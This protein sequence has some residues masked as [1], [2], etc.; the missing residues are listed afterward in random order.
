[1]KHL[2]RRGLALCLSL[3]LLLPSALAVGSF[4]KTNPYSPFPDL[5]GHWAE[6]CVRVCVETGL[7]EG[8][9]GRFAP[10]AVLTN[11]E[12]AAIAARIREVFTGEPIPAAG[13]PWYQVYLDYLARAGI[14]VT[15]PRAYATRQSFFS[16]LS[17]VLP[18]SALTAINSIRALPDTN[19]PAVLKFYN[20]GILTGTDQYGTFDG[21]S[22]L[23]RAQ[24]AAMAARIAEPALRQRFTPAGQVPAADYAD[25]ALVMTVEGVPVTYASFR[26]V[27][28]SLTGEVMELYADYGL[29][30]DWQGGYGVENWNDTLRKAAR[31]SLAAQVLVEQA[32]AKL[33][34][35]PEDLALTLFGAPSEAELNTCAWEQGLDRQSPGVDELLTDIILEEKLNTQ[36]GLWVEQANIVTTPVYETLLA[37]ELWGLYSGYQ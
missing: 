24:C 17:A 11:A 22:P 31:H 27:L 28:L 34:C 2:I 14:T 20:A 3:T 25:D 33:G 35:A 4:E 29:S 30:F 5:S 19:D 1:M 13:S 23:T 15:A 37:E 7:M 26:D 12:A 10:E 21:A 9:G 36:I 6:P 18:D 32:A 8:V 16:L